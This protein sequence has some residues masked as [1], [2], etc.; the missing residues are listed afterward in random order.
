M[1]GNSDQHSDQQSKSEPWAIAQPALKGIL[2][3][4]NGLIPSSG[5][6]PTS[7]NA[8]NSLESNAQAGNPY[9]G[10]ITD[11]VKTLLNGGGATAQAPNI[12]NTLSTYQQQ[13]T[14]FANGSMVGNNT[15]LQKQ[16]AQIQTDVG[17]SVNSQFAAAG[18]DFSGANQMAYGRGVAAA[19]APVIANQYNQDVSNQI[20]AAGALYGAGNTTAGMLAGLTQQDLANRGAGVAAAPDA[21]SAQ[22]YTA[23]QLLQLE[24]LRQAIPA[25]NLGLLAQIGIPIAAL[26]SQSSGS[27]DSQQSMSGAQQFG[28][29]AGGLRGLFGGGGGK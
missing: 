8:I 18:R 28:L 9:S 3:Q 6:S 21:L 25:Q 5:L 1:G 24:Q 26:G 14:P 7:T 23:Q 16:L 12:S 27:S 2:G 4:L 13:L 29:V 17:D 20:N 11:Y 22:N 15:A 19:E 10:Q